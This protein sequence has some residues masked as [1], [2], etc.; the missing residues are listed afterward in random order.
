MELAKIA[1]LD[2]RQRRIEL[3]KM[4]IVEEVLTMKCPREGCR[5][6]RA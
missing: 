3:I 1:Q 4:S 2:E 5:L 6:Y